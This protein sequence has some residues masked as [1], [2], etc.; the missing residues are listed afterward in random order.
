MNML[1]THRIS[2]GKFVEQKL[3]RELAF[4]ET[5]IS[6]ARQALNICMVPPDASY[7]ISRAFFD[8]CLESLVFAQVQKDITWKQ[9]RELYQVSQSINLNTVSGELY[10]LKGDADAPSSS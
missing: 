5:K 1:D 4:L 7:E 10:Y 8:S 3:S 2:T 6:N 9:I